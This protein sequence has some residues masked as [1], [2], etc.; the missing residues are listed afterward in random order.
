V[1]FSQTSTKPNE[2]LSKSETTG[3][4]MY[5]C[6]SITFYLHYTVLWKLLTVCCVT[7]TL[8]LTKVLYQSI[9]KL[10]VV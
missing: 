8:V 5:V 1:E 4:G 9:T 7:H 3:Q 6:V 2:E 10:I